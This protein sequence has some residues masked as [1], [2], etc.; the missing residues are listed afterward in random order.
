MAQRTIG[1]FGKWVR[2]C[3][4]LV[5]CC[6]RT[7][8]LGG[9]PSPSSTKSLSS[10]GCLSSDALEGPA[11][12]STGSGCRSASTSE[13]LG[14]SPPAKLGAEPASLGSSSSAGAELARQ[15]TQEQG[16]HWAQNDVGSTLHHIV[17]HIQLP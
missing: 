14:R 16:A 9:S 3:S 2:K 6:F 17:G 10:I 12:S 13:G 4:G 7:S 11:A 15:L 1:T 8:S 5:A